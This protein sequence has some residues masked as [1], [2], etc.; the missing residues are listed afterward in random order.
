MAQP[1]ANMPARVASG[2]PKV[3]SRHNAGPTLKAWLG[4]LALLFCASFVV[5]LVLVQSH[6][7]NTLG[8]YITITLVLLGISVIP[9]VK[10]ASQHDLA[11]TVTQLRQVNPMPTPSRPHPTSVLWSFLLQPTDANWQPRL[12]RQGFLAPV[13][14][15]TFVP[16]A[17]HGTPVDEGSRVVVRGKAKKLEVKATHIWN[18][19]SSTPQS[20]E[21]GEECHWGRVTDLQPPAQIQDTR[22]PEPRFL[23]V[24]AFRLQPT[25]QAFD[26]LRDQ[27]GDLLSPIP[28]E[29]RARVITGALQEGD[30]V[31]LRGGLVHGML[32]PRQVINHSAGGAALA[33][34]GW[35][36]VVY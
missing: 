27:R 31:E 4:Y 7:V 8:D 14:E 33:I 19:T 32:Y 2:V 18:L 1:A 10:R 23:E 21:A 26:L 13:I 25:S 6:T 29:I 16:Q 12:D 22:S 36:G 28:V 11:G 34:T 24:R 35:A 9:F 5:F 3:P 30:R 17:V 20:S 15:V